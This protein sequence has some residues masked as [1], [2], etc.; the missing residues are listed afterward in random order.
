MLK[1]LSSLTRAYWGVS[2]CSA[3]ICHG[4]AL[5][6]ERGSANRELLGP[7]GGD[8]HRNL[9][10]PARDNHRD[11]P[12]TVAARDEIILVE[13]LVVDDEGSLRDNELVRRFAATVLHARADAAA[14]HHTIYAL[15]GDGAVLHF[16][17]VL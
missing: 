7:R 6:V 5:G 13:D 12:N 17:D 15:V 2:I 9:R 8:A 11:G 14:R 3:R 1:F 16:N 4:V 10:V